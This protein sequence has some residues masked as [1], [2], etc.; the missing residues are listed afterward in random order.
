[1]TSVNV[2]AKCVCPNRL[3]KEREKANVNRIIEEASRGTPFWEHQK[4]RDERHTERIRKT[5]Q[6]LAAASPKELADAK[7]WTV[8]TLQRLDAAFQ[9]SGDKESLRHVVH[10]DMDAFYASVEER[11]DPRLR[12]LPMAV[13]S[14]SMLS[15]S[16]YVARKFGVRAG[17]PGFIARKLCPQLVIVPINPDKYEQASFEVMNILSK[18]DPS[19]TVFGLDEAALDIT[20]YCQSVSET[21]ISPD[22]AVNRLRAAV[23]EKTGL[24]CSAGIAPNGLLAKICADVNKPDGQF[25]LDTLENINKFLTPLKVRKIPGIGQVQEKI[26]SALGIES[27]GDLL[28]NGE[29]LLLALGERSAEAYLRAAKGIGSSY[30]QDERASG[31]GRSRKSKSAEA[32]FHD[33]ADPEYLADVVRQ[34]CVRLSE[35]LITANLRGRLVT[36]KLKTASFDLFSH[37]VALEIATNSESAITNHSLRILRYAL[38]RRKGQALRLLGVK[39]SNFEDERRDS[40]STGRQTTLSQIL[41]KDGLISKTN[42]S[43]NAYAGARTSDRSIDEENSRSS[44]SV[45]SES[46]EKHGHNTPSGSDNKIHLKNSSK[47]TDVIPLTSQSNI[48]DRSRCTDVPS[49]DECQTYVKSGEVVENRPETVPSQRSKSTNT[50]TLIEETYCPICAVIMRGVS[51]R[52]VNR[53]VDECLQREQKHERDMNFSCKVNCAGVRRTNNKKSGSKG[54]TKR[55]G[56]ADRTKSPARGAKQPTNGSITAFLKR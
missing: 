37:S 38:D 28:E 33:T 54:P 1:M 3:G 15:T 53:H 35:E 46:N 32:T 41:A 18:F 34:L 52:H 29:R 14:T 43:S 9:K 40:Y 2:F 4:R 50:E 51:E 44:I 27:C 11:D 36:V 10:V 30:R 7:Q 24:T 13:G 26:L 16:N 55:K 31:H 20:D 45:I 56:T 48:N 25:R 8:S 17:L 19:L 12:G 23:R 6:K 49:T 21:G 22:E 42:N 39:M 47:S 5:L